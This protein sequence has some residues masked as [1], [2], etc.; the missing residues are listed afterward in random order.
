MKVYV[1]FMK[2]LKFSILL[3]FLISFSHF[4][5]LDY[6]QAQSVSKKYN[7]FQNSQWMLAHA[8]SVGVVKLRMK[9]MKVIGAEIKIIGKMVRGKNPF[10][11]SKIA[12]ASERIAGHGRQSLKLF[13]RNI[14]GETSRASPQIWKDWEGFTRAMNTMVQSATEVAEAGRAGNV[15]AVKTAYRALGK[16]CAGCHR[17]YRMSKNRRR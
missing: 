1:T 13:V 7:T 3:P 16:S 9:S 10:D 6:V 8:G 12:K 4:G 11:G 5:P 17:S 14:Q 2:K 15:V